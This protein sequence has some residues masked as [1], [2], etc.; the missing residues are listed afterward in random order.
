VAAERPRSTN[1]RLEAPGGWLSRALLGKGKVQDA[2]RTLEGGSNYGDGVKAVLGVAYA[3]A[4]RGSEA[5]RI[6]AELPSP[7][8][9]EVFAALGDKGRA[10]DA[11][12]RSI[13]L[14][15]TRVGRELNL[16]EFAFLRGDPQ[17]KTL[18]RMVGLPE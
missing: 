10:F 9:A 15:G 1:V 14:G 3:Q 11:L 12:N 18:R 13:P 16:P 7:L 4:G 5:E 2:V 6:A 17:M 8:Q